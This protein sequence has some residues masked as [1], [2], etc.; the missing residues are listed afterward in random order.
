MKQVAFERKKLAANFFAN[1]GV[2]WFASGVIG[3]FI[4][5]MTDKNDI[6]V[7]LIWGVGYGFLFL[8]AGMYVLKLKSK[9]K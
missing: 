4:N 7:S 6:V 9:G 5:Q 1:I 8:F 2:A 3:I